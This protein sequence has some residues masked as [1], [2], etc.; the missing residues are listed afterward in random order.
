MNREDPLGLHIRVIEHILT[1]RMER[2]ISSYEPFSLYRLAHHR[3]QSRQ[4]MKGQDLLP[5]QRE[6]IKFLNLADPAIDLG[7]ILLRAQEMLSFSQRQSNVGNVDP[8]HA[9]EHA[10]TVIQQIKISL[11]EL[12]AWLD[13]IPS[14]WRPQHLQISEHDDIRL[15]L[16]RA[17]LPLISRVRRYYDPWVAYQNNFYLLGQLV[18]RSALL[19]TLAG[20]MQT[21]FD[22]DRSVELQHEFVSQ[23]L[24]MAEHSEAIIESIPLLIA[25]SVEQALHLDVFQK[26]KIGQCFAQAACWTLQQ[27]QHV[28]PDHRAFA[29]QALAWLHQQTSLG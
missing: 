15:L 20:I 17:S 9:E 8:R 6:C 29:D 24:G 28:P 3:L 4:L 23:E 26:K 5:V 19:D 2:N 12:E 10:L 18:L 11:T 13:R 1:A 16:D 25:S 7:A 21:T 14:S 27:I 22:I